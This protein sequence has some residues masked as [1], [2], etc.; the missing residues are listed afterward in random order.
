MERVLPEGE[1]HCQKKNHRK[2]WVCSRCGE[3]KQ[4]QIIPEGS[5]RRC[6]WCKHR[7]H[8]HAIWVSNLTELL[9]NNPVME[10]CEENSG[11][12]GENPKKTRQEFC[13]FSFFKHRIV[14]GMCI[15]V[16]PRG[17][18]P[19]WV[20]SSLLIITAVI[21]LNVYSILSMPPCVACPC[22]CTQLELL[23][24]LLRDP[25]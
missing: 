9:E 5:Q 3:T 22:I 13:D 6:C 4:C 10:S 2:L 11:C 12:L 17:N 15:H 1:T 18:G 16:P 21:Q 23:R 8:L 14:L 24:T 19:E 7:R 20:Y 25:S